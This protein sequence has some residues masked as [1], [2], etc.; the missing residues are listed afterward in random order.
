MTTA[1][2]TGPALPV[3]IGRALDVLAIL[4]VLVA[5]WQAAFEYAGAV[6]ITSPAHTV[7]FAASLLGSAGFWGDAGATALAFAYSFVIAAVLGVLGGLML[8]LWRYAA[9]VTEPILTALYTIPKVTLYPVILLLFGLGD[10]AKVAFGVL[11]GMPPV[12]IMTAT[13]I[14]GLKPI[15][16]KAALTM[17]LTPQRYATGILMPAVMPEI[18]AGFRICFAQALLGVLVGEMFASV[19]GVGHLLM[20]SIGVDDEPTIMAIVVIVFLFAG[21]GSAA[22]LALAR[23]RDG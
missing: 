2:P 6:A 12:V 10:A 17:R 22:L 18:L 19:H 9:D 7:A 5:A 13:A 20:A 8:G 23:R 3:K 15:Y 4:A 1:T 21:S 16:R 14:R 11:H